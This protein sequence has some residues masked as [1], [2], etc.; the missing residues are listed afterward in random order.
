MKYLYQQLLAFWVIIVMMILIVGVSFT[1][2]TKRTMEENNYQQL[3]RYADSVRENAELIS[4]NFP[5]MTDGEALGVYLRL[6]EQV[7][8]NQ[9]VRFYFVDTDRIVNYPNDEHGDLD[10]NVSDQEWKQL[11]NGNKIQITKKS[12]F[13][14]ADVRTAYAM[15]PYT[16]PKIVNGEVQEAFYGALIVT[17]PVSNLEKSLEPT[18]TN[19]LKGFMISSIV[20]V[21]ISY[22]FANFQVR[23]INRMR[24]ATREIAD[25]NFDIE[26]EVNDRDE[27][28]ELAADF[29]QMTSSLKESHEEIERQ[30]ERRRQ[31]MADAAH[32][33]RTPLTTINGLL[34]GLEYHAIPED[35]QDDAIRLM[36]NETER[37]IRLVNENLDYEK[38]RT[39]QI[40]IVI[41]KFDAT[42]ALR[43][44]VSQM[45]SKAEAANDQLI[46]DTTESI[47]VFADYD[48][49][50]QIMV[51]IIQNA[52][53]FTN[54]GE[55]HVQ[56][57]KGYLET[58]IKISDTGIGMSEE[59][60][61]N[62]WERY[63]KA[64]PSRKNTKYGESGLGLSIV[65]QLVK[66]HKGTVLV[67]SELDKGTTFTV[68]FPDVET[69]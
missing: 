49:F 24:K 20:A 4:D 26:L 32:E 63:F 56:V 21:F 60:V 47:E 9:A 69:E 3:F 22:G 36:K 7:L 39:N 66:L 58:I 12:N 13:S 41:K 6:T 14:G 30:E 2:F 8:S 64:D 38:I 59:D 40:G 11:M 48:R 28:D 62:I 61:Q 25:G 57:Q 46:L 5:N 27:F 34:E 15:V 31:F 18:T 19:L 55:I 68:S 17:Q 35:K 52:I 33:M 37:L 54:N 29:N 16:V 23:R 42:K 43:S 67:E 44:I 1:Q 45:Q 51:N 50:V 65:Q 53:Q 10:F